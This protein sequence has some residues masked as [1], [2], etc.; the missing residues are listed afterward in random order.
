MERAVRGSVATEHP[1]LASLTPLIG[2]ESELL[3]LQGMLSRTR[4][5]TVTGAGG[6]G[7]TRLALALA[8]RLARESEDLECVFVGL[9]AVAG[10]GQVL[11]V[12]LGALGVRERF[13]STPTQ[14]LVERVARGRVLFVLDNCEHLLSVIGPLTLKLLDAAPRVRVLATSR[15]PLAIGGESVFRLEP[16]SL[17]E[18]DDGL[19][20]VVRSEAGRMFVERAARVDRAF[21]LTPTSARAIVRICHELDGLPLALAL[22]AARMDVLTAEE[23]AQSL[24]ESGRLSASPSRGQAVAQEMEEGVGEA[25]GS[26]DVDELSRHGS[27]RASLDWSYRLLEEPEQ[28]LLRSLSVFSGGFTAAAAHAIGMPDSS[29]EFVRSLLASLEAKGLTMPLPALGEPRWM[30]LET[31]REYAAEHLERHGEREDVAERH[32]EWFAA[33][34]IRADCLLAEPDGHERVEEE[35]ANLSLAID[36]ALAHDPP[37]ALEIAAALMRHWILAEHYQRARSICAAVLSAVPTE[38]V[39]AGERSSMSMSMSAVSLSALALVHCGAGLVGLLSEDYAGAIASTQA[40]L[41][42]LGEVGDP[43]VEASCL[44]FSSMV[45]IQ[46][47]ADPAGGLRNIERAVKLARG[48]DDHLGL[49]L[50]LVNLA[51]AMML[52]ERFEAVAAA[53][54]EFL[55]IQGAC[56]H[57]RLRAWAEQ[58]AAWQ[59]VSVGSPVRS[60]VHVERALELEGEWP[61]MTYF[62]IVGFRIH[63]LARLGRADQALRE[64]AE[65]MRQ[66][67]ESGALQ[68]IPAI[69][70]ALMVAE[71]MN[72]TLDAAEDRAHRLLEMPH[73]HTLALARETLGRIALERGDLGAVDAHACELEA[74]AQ[75]SDSARYR[76]IADYLQ[77][78]A[79]VEAGEIDTGRDLLHT[80]LLSCA[81][82]GL[83]REAADVLDELALLAAGAGDVERGARL[84]GAAA[85]A[86][87]R[88]DCV[89][90]PHAIQRLDT[91][92][93]QAIDRDSNGRWE[94]AWAQGEALELTDA[95]EYARRGRGR[96]DRPARGWASL[97]PV[98]S[99][100]ATLA[101]EG[102]TNPQ[103]AQRMYISRGTVKTHL[104][105]AYKKLG[106]SN[107]FEL[108]AASAARTSEQRAAEA[109]IDAGA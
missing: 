16:L 59:Q 82:L 99:E 64:G 4:V 93:T 101:A 68:A 75:Q 94:K 5:L 79:A 106:V 17:P 13:G 87:S 103:I 19:A 26:G 71:L 23:I 84:A 34:A 63:A 31:V 7:K 90:A 66:A 77:G 102:L 39:D 14:V 81:E 30:P 88:L 62:Q 45:L 48:G 43:S 50:A 54:D 56:E 46:T 10:E 36:Y 6:C 108:T 92:R 69:D 98:E 91:A 22:A 72:G 1:E 107:R 24:A 74:I 76:V 67:R 109:S 60:L 8:D 53:Y 97:S 49:A 58:A 95:I 2:R 96:R 20:G 11:D 104:S 70:L 15:A 78:R 89:P 32:C 40:G 37:R 85:T 18:V 105:H 86:R 33:Y 35:R 3:C 25:G 100:V 42:L 29:P 21:S 38:D 57:P 73:M 65:A 52:C 41:A 28:M 9:S 51:V 44:M 61:S 83:Q 27:V 80:A 47:A 55:R 12:L